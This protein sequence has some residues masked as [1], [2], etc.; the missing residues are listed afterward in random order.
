LQIFAKNK[1]LQTLSNHINCLLA[2][3]TAAWEDLQAKSCAGTM[4]N[5]NLILFYTF[6]PSPMFKQTMVI[7]TFADIC[8][9]QGP[10]DL[11]KSHKLPASNSSSSSSM[12]R[13]SS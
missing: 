3:T 2:A 10:T 9:K 4:K 1:V 6:S 12:G 11:I 8:K 7:R 13:P 5:L